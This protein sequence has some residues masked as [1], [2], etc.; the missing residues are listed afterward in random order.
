MTKPC[1][2]GTPAHRWIC[3]DPVHDVGIPATCALC[4]QTHTFPIHVEPGWNSTVVRDRT[5]FHHQ[6]PKY[7]M[8]DEVTT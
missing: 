5:G 6:R 3:G 4:Q 1:K 7:M 2:D 8:S